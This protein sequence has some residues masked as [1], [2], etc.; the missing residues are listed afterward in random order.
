MRQLTA[1]EINHLNKSG[2][3]PTS[4]SV[5]QTE[6]PVEYMSGSA[7]FYNRFFQVN[8]NVLIPRVETEKLI[9]IALLETADAKKKLSIADIGTGSGAIGITLAIEMLKR[10]LNFNMYLSDISEDA[11]A[12]CFNN[13]ELLTEPVKTTEFNKQFEFYYSNKSKIKLFKSNLLSDYSKSIRF[14]LILAN[15]PYI[16]KS[17]MSKL[18]KSVKDFEPELALNGGEEGLELILELLVQA[19]PQLKKN[20]KML[21]EVDD[22]HTFGLWSTDMFKEDREYWDLKVLKDEN[23]KVRYWI[24]SKR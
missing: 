5:L 6:K 2:I 11:L 23:E 7:E 21:L 24:C 1:R 10:N 15:L 4:K 22:T 12:V 13:I 16:P 19:Y 20:G 17:R 8:E 18:D 3:D 9:D 14:D